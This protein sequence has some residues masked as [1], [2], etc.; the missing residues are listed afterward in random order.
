MN[1]KPVSG[2]GSYLSKEPVNKTTE[3][4]EAPVQDKLEISAEAK[5]IQQSDVDMKKINEIKLR[6]KNNFYNSPEV[7][8]KVA[9]K[10]LKEFNK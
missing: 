4:K 3:K 9:E 6:I 10:I 5:K 1:I 7:L 2:N 8:D